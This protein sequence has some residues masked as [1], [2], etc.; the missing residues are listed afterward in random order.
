V[1][2]TSRHDT[3][4]VVSRPTVWLRD[5][6]ARWLSAGRLRAL[7]ALAERTADVRWSPALVFGL[8][9]ELPTDDAFDELVEDLRQRPR[10]N[11]AQVLLLALA[12]RHSW[13]SDALSRLLRRLGL[14]ACRPHPTSTPGHA[15]GI[16]GRLPSHPRPEHHVLQSR[17]R[18]RSVKA[19]RSAPT[20]TGHPNAAAA[21]GGPAGGAGGLDG[22][23][24]L[25]RRRPLR[26]ASGSQPPA[27]RGTRG[28][29]G[30]HHG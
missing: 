2:R 30:R 20:P 1:V 27:L 16:N 19:L 8:L 28:R 24:G 26:D 25:A 7:R 22:T 14:R 13:R 23:V 3:P 12:A 6:A 29:K 15:K 18:L 9:E 5:D 21:S 4:L 10:V 11:F 17:A